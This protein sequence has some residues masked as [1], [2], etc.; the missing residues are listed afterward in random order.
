MLLYCLRVYSFPG[1]YSVSLLISV[2]MGGMKQDE[3]ISIVED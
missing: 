2:M 1:L 3:V